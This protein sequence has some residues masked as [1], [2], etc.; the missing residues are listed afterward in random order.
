MTWK[1]I[2]RGNPEIFDASNIDEDFMDLYY[3]Q[4][5]SIS[6]GTCSKCKCEPAVDCLVFGDCVIED[7][8]YL[9]PCYEYKYTQW[10]PRPGTMMILEKDLFEI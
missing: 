5:R 4:F 9:K 7:Y 6:C 2:K 3:D 1:T 10:T 8:G